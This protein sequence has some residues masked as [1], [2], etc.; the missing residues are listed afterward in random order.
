[1]IFPLYEQLTEDICPMQLSG[2]CTFVLY[3]LF[4]VLLEDNV[5]NYVFMRVMLFLKVVFHCQPSPVSSQIFCQIS[6]KILLL[7]NEVHVHI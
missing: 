6:S 4:S 3:I 5:S 2:H 7:I 1:M